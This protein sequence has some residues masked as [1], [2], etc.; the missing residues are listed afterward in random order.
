MKKKWAKIRRGDIV[1]MGGRAWTVEAIKVGK[2][3]ADVKVRSG[4]RTAESRVSID[5]KVKLGT[6]PHKS[7]A[8]PTRTAEKP[9]SRIP[10]NPPK[11]PTGNPWETQQDRIERKMD[12]ILSARLVGEQTD[13]DSG[14]YV[15][16]ADVTTIAA[17]MLIFHGGLPD[18]TETQMLTEHARQHDENGVNQAL[19]HWHTE[20]RPKK[21]KKS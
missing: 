2:K 3:K 17:H 4:A 11:A 19:P 12:E 8:R 16:P 15:P 14:Y 9:K 18:M 21:A 6:E 1:E 13:P 7:A 10:E 20:R 5:D